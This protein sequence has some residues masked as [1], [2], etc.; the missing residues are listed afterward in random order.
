MV[1]IF[2]FFVQ[3]DG[4][5]FMVAFTVFGVNYVIALFARVVIYCD[6][7]FDFERSGSMISLVKG[8][9]PRFIGDNDKTLNTCPVISLLFNDKSFLFLHKPTK[10]IQ[11]VWIPR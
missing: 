2:D 7:I 6:W 11:L 1:T 5:R 9:S 4:S 3:N 8:P 10:N